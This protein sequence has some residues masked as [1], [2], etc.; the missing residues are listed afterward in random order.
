MRRII[1]I[2]MVLSTVPFIISADEIN[3]W[4]VEYIKGYI[5]RVYINDEGSL[6][7]IDLDDSRGIS[8]SGD[9]VLL[10]KLSKQR[11]S[12]A[13]HPGQYNFNELYSAVCMAFISDLKIRIRPVLDGS[14]YRGYNIVGQLVLLKE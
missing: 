12:F 1:I 14:Y 2:L 11:A 13:I 8:V 10:T 6:V 4:N 9:R 3:N 5:E 7:L